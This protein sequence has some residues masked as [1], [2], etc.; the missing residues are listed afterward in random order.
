MNKIL[1]FF[2]EKFIGLSSDF[3]RPEP[4]P[5]PQKKEVDTDLDIYKWGQI[6]KLN[7][8][9]SEPPI[10]ATQPNIDSKLWALSS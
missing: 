5:D 3:C 6:R 1:G 2:L 10:K 9:V 4:E 7:N 8:G